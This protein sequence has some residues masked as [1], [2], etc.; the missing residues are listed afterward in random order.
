MKLR[1]KHLLILFVLM[2]PSVLFPKQTSAQQNDVNFQV[3]YDALSPYGEW[4]DYKNYGYAWIPDAGPDFVPYSTAGYWV[5]TNYGWTWVSDYEWGWAPFHYGRWD[6][7]NYY[8]WLWIP[9]NEWGPSWVNW[10]RADGYYGW[11]PMEPGVSLSISFGRSYNSYND[12]WMFVRDMDFERR[13]LNRYFVNRNDR[14]SII[15]N[16]SVINRTYID[17]SRHTTYVTGPAREDVQRVTGRRINPVSIRENN[18][19]GQDLSNGQMNIYRPQVQKNIGNQSRPAPARVSD[20]RDIKRPSER[21]SAT[22]PRNVR[23]PDNRIS[24]PTQQRSFAPANDAGRQQSPDVAKPRNNVNRVQP[25]QEPQRQSPQAQP[26]E[27]RSPQQRQRQQTQPQEQRQRQQA[28]TSG[29]ASATASSTSGTT[30]TATTS[31][32]ATATITAGSATATAFASATTDPASTSTAAS[33]TATASISTAA[34]STATPV[35]AAA[36]EYGKASKWQES[37]AKRG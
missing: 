34:I 4:V 5:S 20:L 33:S 13:D 11:S 35:S 6:Y 28:T 32:S 7:D 10:R 22:Q 16:S 29:T 31:A 8:G 37:A 36:A 17:N 14:A 19:P 23:L 18:R 12:H 24:Q 25:S 26:Q 30:S 15:R 27:Q 1:I 3:F 2:M 21:N 9:D